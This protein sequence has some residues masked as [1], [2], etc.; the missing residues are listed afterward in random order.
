V[1]SGINSRLTANIQEHLEGQEGMSGNVELG[2]GLTTLVV[3]CWLG[4]P[5]P[6][7]PSY[8]SSIWNSRRGE[9]VSTAKGKEGADPYVYLR[10]VDR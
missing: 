3:C 10:E 4:L 6:K 9:L 7:W 2:L 1:P 5:I 8:I